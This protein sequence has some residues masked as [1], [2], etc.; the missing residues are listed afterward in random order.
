VIDERR[1]ELLEQKRKIIKRQIALQEAPKSL[2]RFMSLMLYDEED[3][4]DSDKSR[5]QFVPHCRLLCEIVARIELGDLKR[6]AISIPPQHSKTWHLSIYGPAWILGRNPRANIVV[7]TYNE[8]RAKEL[9]EDFR[10]VV[11][12][13]LYRAIFP[14]VELEIGSKSK[15]SMRTTR[16]GKIFFV[17]KGGTTTGRAT[18]DGYF[19]VDDPIKGD[20]EDL[21]SD[22]GRDKDWKWFFKIAY[23]RGNKNTRMVVLHTRWHGDD[24]IGRLCDPNH[25]ERDK[26]FAH[27]K[28]WDYINL[29]GVITDKNL[30]DA[31]GLKL[32]KPTDPNVIAAF[33]SEPMVA[34]WA[35]DKDLNFFADWKH[36]DA[37]GFSALVMG[38]PTLEG[39]DYFKAEWLIEYDAQELPQRLTFYG[40]SDHA[41]STKQGR[42]YTVL[43]CVGV[44]E[45]DNIWVLPDLVHRRM[46]TAQTVEELLLQFKMHKPG[47]WWMESELISKSFGPFLKQRMME[48]CIYTTID[49]VVVS[50]DKRTR[51]RAISGRLSMGKVRFPRFAPWWQ[52]MK[53][54]LLQFDHG[55]HDDFVDWLAHIGMG[56]L[57]EIAPSREVAVSN[58]VP[59]VGSPQWILRQTKLRGDRDKRAAGTKGW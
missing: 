51:A 6:C 23:S 39:G 10:S 32:E 57:K 15:D 53:S 26:E 45:H 19:F 54:E 24:L 52:T 31:L 5:Y 3:P 48:E 20:E 46:D 18:G 34:L 1:R 58:V 17:S 36:G 16:G 22:G 28:G 2:P 59:M 8:T 42:D 35:A 33:G 49:A 11:D 29:P 43:G 55:A 56:L 21:Q 27:V 30:A 12:S 40:A 7:A 25:P 47:L 13:P 41:V 44:D 50:K 14:K 37:Q 9:G 38:Q 4:L